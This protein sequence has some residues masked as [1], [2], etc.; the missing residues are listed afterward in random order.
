MPFDRVNAAVR[1]FNALSAQ[2]SAFMIVA[3]A[4]VLLSEILVRYILAWSTDW[5]IEFSVMLLIVS[6]FMSAAYT[7]ATRGHVAIEL[8]DEISPPAMTRWRLALA[9]LLSLLFCAF[10]AWKM[11]QLFHEGWSE[12]RV[13]DT[14]WGPHLWPLFAFMA[15]GMAMLAIELLL[16]LLGETLPAALGRSSR[17]PGAPR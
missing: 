8:L 11:A 13:S 15:F 3:A 16:Q 4:C 17:H 14:S 7:Q 6:T 1:R 5:E 9:D 2:A 12:N 10:V